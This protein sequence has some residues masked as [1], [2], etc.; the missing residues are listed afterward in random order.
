MTE[1]RVNGA[2]AILTAKEKNGERGKGKE[3]RERK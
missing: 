2:V 3:E 1:L